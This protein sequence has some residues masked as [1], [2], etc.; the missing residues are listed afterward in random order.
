MKW[1]KAKDEWPESGKLVLLTY[2]DVNRRYTERTTVVCHRCEDRRIRD[3]GYYT[4]NNV[5]DHW[6]YIE[7]PED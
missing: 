5:D 1:H 3:D 6:A 7:L 4:I 2:W